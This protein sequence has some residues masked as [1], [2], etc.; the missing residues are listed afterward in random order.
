M[1][2]LTKLRSDVK[3][4][5]EDDFKEGGQRNSIQVRVPFLW[6]DIY[7]NTLTLYPLPRVPGNHNLGPILEGYGVLI[8]F[9][10]ASQSS[11]HVTI[12]E[13]QAWSIGL[14]AEACRGP[15]AGAGGV[16]LR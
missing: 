2:Q 5:L 16:F 11:I 6:M 10:S 9:R 15:Q 14:G 3:R 12:S 1:M 13:F 7:I 8:R 4:T